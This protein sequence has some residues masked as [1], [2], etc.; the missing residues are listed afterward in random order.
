MSRL[1]SAF[2]LRPRWVRYVAV[3]AAVALA[4]GCV[5]GAIQAFIFIRFLLHSRTAAAAEPAAVAAW[6]AEFGDPQEL[7]ASIPKQPDDNSTAVTL[8]QKAQELG[9][10][11][12]RPAVRP[13]GR[14][15]WPKS[16]NAEVFR[17]ISDYVESELRKVGLPISPPPPPVL[18][19]LETHRS[20][21]DGMIEFLVGSEPPRW[22]M[23]ETA[24]PESP[25]PNVSRLIRLHRVLAAEALL[26]AQRGDDAGADK[27]MRASWNLSASLRD[28]PEVTAQLIAI[29]IA[30]MQAGLARRIPTLP[31]EEWQARFQ[32]HD[33]R[34]SLLHAFTVQASRRLASLPDD[35]STI[36][37]ATH[38]DLMN[39]ERRFL[40]ACRDSPVSDES[41]AVERVAS[42]EP[43]RS[44]IGEILGSIAI[45]GLGD[46]WNRANRLVVDLEL[47]TKALEARAQRARLG[48]WPKEIPGLEKSR[49]SGAHWIYSVSDS[50]RMSIACSVKPE[51]LR[52]QGLILPL[53]FSEE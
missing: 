21:V 3:V 48:H 44:S 32:E 29:S 7:L 2:A 33:Y 43:D 36:S 23:G 53:E 49:L 19:F 24:G 31:A 27:V 1:S 38:A 52:P 28:R 10:S 51:W 4:A 14:L 37:R 13:D 30:R 16:D 40:V 47:T 39:M 25:L 9:I 20:S 41:D 34:A 45:G 22:K 42:K 8:V 12:A 18:A 6:R 17:S 15:D 46:S 26:R 5:F 11:M 35:R 50:G